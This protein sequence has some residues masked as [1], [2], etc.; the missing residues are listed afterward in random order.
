MNRFSLHERLAADCHLVGDLPLCRVLLLDDR[1]YA[2][3]ILVPRREAI[4][5]IH[6]LDGSDREALMAESCALGEFMLDGFPGDKLNVAAL[7]NL[8]PQL[9]LHHVVRHAGDPAWPGPV[10][11][12]SA[13]QAYSPDERDRRVAI[14]RDGLSVAEPGRS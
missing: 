13:A 4:R 1:R 11:G 6:E 5:E 8:V 12:H 9:H 7:G 2:W 3:V 14:L 10:W